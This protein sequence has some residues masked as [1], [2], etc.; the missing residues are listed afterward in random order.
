M[1]SPA[2]LGQTAELAA[3]GLERKP[4][5]RQMDD[6]A[7]RLRWWT[8]PNTAQAFPAYAGLPDRSGGP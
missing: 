2:A 8:L 3:H 1:P 4:S 7:V 6:G 5:G